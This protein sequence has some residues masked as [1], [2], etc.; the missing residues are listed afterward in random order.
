MS[1]G[2]GLGLTFVLLA[3]NALFV[4]SEFAL[5]SARR[6][7]LEP[8]AQAGSRPA[9]LALRAMENVTL[10]MAAA[11]L[12]ITICSLGLGAISE[13]ALA[14]LLE[15]GFEALSVP[16]GLVDPIAFVIAMTFIVFLHVV[17]GE[18]VPKNLAL[19]G[20]DR[21][22]LFLGPFMLGVVAV[23]KP[24]VVAL[25]ATANAAVRLLRIEPVDE[26]ASTYTHDE[27][28]GLV[29][30]SRREGL[31]DEEMVAAEDW[32][33]A[34]RIDAADLLADVAVFVATL[35]AKQRAALVMRKQHDAPYPEIAAALGCS[36]AAARRS[37]H[38]GLRKVRDRFA[39]RLQEVAE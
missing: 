4:A 15:P 6:T 8:L 38:E 11:Q 13:P 3:L 16:E 28:A 25:N 23:L 24:F 9:K 34:T 12:G 10:A 21:A 37:V 22:A 31:L 20:P 7:Q 30:E 26:V 27:V 35:P 14:H 18:M 29:E 17:F 5:I 33:I 19:V 32:D 2:F 1:T 39:G 36:E